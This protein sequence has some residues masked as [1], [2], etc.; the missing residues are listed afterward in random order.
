MTEWQPYLDTLDKTKQE[1]IIHVMDIAIKYIPN[2][3]R[4]ISYGVPAIKNGNFP[5][6]AVAANKNHLSVYPFSGA[7]VEANKALLLEAEH[8]KGMIRFDYDKLP[9]DEIIKALVQFKLGHSK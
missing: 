7:A 4:M 5:I 2:P 8:S 6:I 3:R 1:A 9:S